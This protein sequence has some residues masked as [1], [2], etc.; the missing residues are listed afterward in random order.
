MIRGGSYGVRYNVSSSIFIVGGITLPPRD[1]AAAA[2]EERC[3]DE[4]FDY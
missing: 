1:A 3:G 4:G 2:E